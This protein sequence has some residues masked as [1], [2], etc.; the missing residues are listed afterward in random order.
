MG[1]RNENF[2]KALDWLFDNGKVADQ[3]ELS[4]VTGINPATISRILNGKVKEPS[5]ETLR[6]LNTTFGGVFNM[7]Y[8]RGKSEEMLAKSEVEETPATHAM[9]D[10]SSMI[11][12][13]LAAKDE[14]ICA[15]KSELARADR[16]IAD[17]QRQL[18]DKD[19]IIALLKAKAVNLDSL[20]A[21]SQANLLK[22]PFP[23][24]V[25]DDGSIEGFTEVK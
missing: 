6:K 19:E 14:A 13:M 17:M 24:G 18:D 4:K 8:F 7:D 22:Y 25:A 11:N 16:Q 23:I 2:A 1:R 20:V 9:S 12:A 21:K 10:Q 5:E 3:K 15:L